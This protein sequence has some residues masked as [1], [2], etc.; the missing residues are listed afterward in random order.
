LAR[1]APAGLMRRP[2]ELVSRLGLVDRFTPP[3]NLI[4]SNVRGPEFPLFLDGGQ[5]THVFPMGPLFEGCGVN[6]TVASYLDRVGFGFL[7]CPALVTDLEGLAAAVPTALH[8]L[9]KAADG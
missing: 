7:G 4:I 3:V 2:M 6:V 5:I 9:V 1:L 8:E